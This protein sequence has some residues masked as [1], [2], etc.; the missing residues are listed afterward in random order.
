MSKTR[1]PSLRLLMGFEAAARHGNFSRAADELSLSQSAVS[2]Q[3]QQLETQLGQP[4]FRRVGRGVEL[5]VAGEVLQRSVQRSV[6]VLRSGLGRINAY[7]DPGLVALVAPAAL[8]QGWLLPRLGEMQ[9]AVP[10][11]CP[12]LSSDTSARFVDEIDVDLL[13]SDRP[14]QQAGLLHL[15]LLQDEWLTV[16][17]AGLAERLAAL[18]PDQYAQHT[19]LL[20]LEDDLTREPSAAVLRGPLGSL[21]R[22]AIFDDPQLLLSAVQQ[23]LGLACMSSLQADADL[24][25][26]RL[27]VLPRGPRLPGSQWWLIRMAGPARSPFIEQCCSWLLAQGLHRVG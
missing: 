1:I 23:G 2:H 19:Q 18:A 7:M 22:R 14:L 20:C 8:L 10:G 3:I 15:P 27:R 17:D 21:R 6:D 13:I 11:L 16:A 26:G 25:A 24:R 4:L 12:L 5:T 9:Q